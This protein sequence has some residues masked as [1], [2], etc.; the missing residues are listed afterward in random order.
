HKVFTFAP[1]ADASRGVL[2]SE[3]FQDADTV[4]RLL[5]DERLHGNI[6]GQVIWIDEAGLLSSRTMGQVFELARTLDARVILSGDRRQHGSV[7]RGSPLHLLEE[8]AGLVPAE[9]REI[10]RQ[11]GDYKQA[12]AALSQG[13]TTEG[14]RRLERLGWVREAGDNERY[15]VL[16]AD[17]VG[18]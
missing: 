18:A 7:E 6:R 3:G 13:S 16:A 10:R 4:A 17:Y 8:E 9:I 2:R 15:K 14:F 5:L 11:Q 1:S 12:V